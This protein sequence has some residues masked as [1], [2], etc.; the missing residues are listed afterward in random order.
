[1]SKKRRS[2]PETGDVSIGPVLSSLLDR[3]PLEVRSKT[4]T[5]ALWNADAP[6]P[7]SRIRDVPELLELADLTNSTVLTVPKSI[8]VTSRGSFP[9]V[10]RRPFTMRPRD[11]LS[12][13]LYVPAGLQAPPSIDADDLNLAEAREAAAGL[14][15]SLQTKY[16]ALNNPLAILGFKA[17]NDM[18]Q[19]LQEKTQRTPRRPKARK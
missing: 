15:E 16:H 12:T 18:P 10:G 5:N 7:A 19:A 4:P 9:R 6:L 3:I 17:F 1:M 11:T 8:T 14:I 2:V 13:R